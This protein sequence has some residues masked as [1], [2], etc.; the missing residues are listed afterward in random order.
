MGGNGPGGNGIAA[1]PAGVFAVAPRTVA[2]DG[3]EL[4]VDCGRAVVQPAASGSN[5]PIATAAAQFR[6]D[7]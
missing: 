2:A 4:L 3:L 1:G 7:L 5:T 6:I